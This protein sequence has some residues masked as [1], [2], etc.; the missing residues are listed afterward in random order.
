MPFLKEEVIF[1]SSPQKCFLRTVDGNQ[2]WIWKVSN[3]GHYEYYEL[4]LASENFENIGEQ[5]PF[6]IEVGG[7]GGISFRNLAEFLLVLPFHSFFFTF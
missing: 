6:N 5:V 1:L 3:F 4:R 7:G 2:L